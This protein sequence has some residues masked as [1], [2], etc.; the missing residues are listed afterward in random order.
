MQLKNMVQLLLWEDGHLTV[1]LGSP[2]FLM[3]TGVDALFYYKKCPVLA[4]SQNKN[5]SFSRKMT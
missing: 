3:F 4:I 1:L 2:N 5:F